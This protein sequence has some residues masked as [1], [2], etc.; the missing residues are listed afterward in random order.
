MFAEVCAVDCGSHGVCIGGSCRCEEGWTG[1]VCDL[2]ACHPRCTEH[3]TCKDGKCECHQG[4]TGEHCTVGKKHNHRYVSINAL[5]GQKNVDTL[6]GFLIQVNFSSSITNSIKNEVWCGCI[7]LASTKPR[8]E[9]H[10][11]PLGWIW[12]G[13]LPNMSIWPCWFL[14]CLNGSKSHSCIATSSGKASQ[15]NWRNRS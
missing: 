6:F 10:R 11:T 14:L 13:L 4:W 5:H 2:K 7:R 8:P 1:S 9:L 15:M 3:G 12:K